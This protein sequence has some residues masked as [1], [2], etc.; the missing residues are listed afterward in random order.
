[1]E[2]NP[3]EELGLTE[4]KQLVLS[5]DGILSGNDYARDLC[6]RSI[7]NGAHFFDAVSR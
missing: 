5:C 4:E 7:R 3:M 6:A 2:Y 1:M